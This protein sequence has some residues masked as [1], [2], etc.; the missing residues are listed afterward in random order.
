MK[1][2]I[3]MKF[4]SQY[5]KTKIHRNYTNAGEKLYHTCH[6]KVKTIHKLHTIK[7]VNPKTASSQNLHIWP[8][9]RALC[10]SIII[11][12]LACQVKHFTKCPQLP[13]IIYNMYVL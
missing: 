13:H 4:K 8:F 10:P 5:L 11:S 9:H 12:R 3:K 6:Q 1:F 2:K 7:F